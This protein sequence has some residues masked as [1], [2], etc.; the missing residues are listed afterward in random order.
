M[1]Q[2]NKL[3]IY[4]GFTQHVPLIDKSWADVINR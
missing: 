3:G 4:V 2:K 1:E